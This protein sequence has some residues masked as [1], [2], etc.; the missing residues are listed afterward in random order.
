MYVWVSFAFMGWAYYEASGGADF[1]PQGQPQPIFAK[2]EPAPEP[3]IVARADTADLTSISTSNY[4]APQGALIVPA[5]FDTPQDP[6]EEVVEAVAEAA[7][8]ADLREVSGARVNMRTGP[9]TNFGVIETLPRGTDVEVLE[10]NAD[11]WA[12]LVVSQSGA[13]GWMAERLLSDPS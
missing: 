8:P 3:E 6:V 1:E 2:Y 9:G 11:G 5:S 10:V 12:R 13:E 7:A 4:E